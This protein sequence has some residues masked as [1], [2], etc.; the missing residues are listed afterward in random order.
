MATETETT[1]LVICAHTEDRW[2]DI[3]EAIQ[4]ARD[5]IL[6]PDEIVLVIDHN[7]ALLARSRN[8]FPD[9]LV[10]PNRGPRGLSGARNTGI[11]VSHGSL[12]AFLD[13]DAVADTYWLL[14]LVE[15]CREPSTLGAMGMIAPLWVG[16]RPGWLPDEYLWVVGCSYLGQP[17]T[18]QEV[19]NLL[20]AGMAIKRSVFDRAGGFNAAMGRQ[21]ASFPLSCEETEM[22]IRAGGMFPDGRFM[23]EPSAVVHHKVRAPRL[24]WSYFSLRCYAEGVS[25]AYVSTFA[26]T[27]RALATEASYATKTLPR[28]FLRGVGD[29]LLRFDP[30]GIKRSAAIV[31]GL[32]CAGAGYLVGI[33][34]PPAVTRGAFQPGGTSSPEKP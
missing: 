12:I 6:P 24:N 17:G 15:R 7:P 20:G 30:D 8:A 34:S 26:A 9:V 4:S 19:R 2:E 16:R 13:D 28:G 25:K 21:H 31:L 11:G 18:V 23:M 3:G 27:P 29:F 1:S 33:A 32:A 14:H 5:Q 10:V 22:C